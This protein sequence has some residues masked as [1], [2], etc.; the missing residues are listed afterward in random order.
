[1]PAHHAHRTLA[2]TDAVPV[3]DTTRRT[4][5]KFSMRK[6]A[7]RIEEVLDREWRLRP[8]QGQL[9][10]GAV[11]NGISLANVPAGMIVLE[12]LGILRRRLSR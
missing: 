5:T 10:Q 12:G 8:S 1:M 3:P 11:P 2:T 4:R 6:S 7:S 9:R